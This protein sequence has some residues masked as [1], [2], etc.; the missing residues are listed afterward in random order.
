MALHPKTSRERA[1]IAEVPATK[2]PIG[3]CKKNAPKSQMGQSPCFLDAEAA[4]L[5]IFCPMTG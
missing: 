1:R 3:G 2:L 5:K 4:A